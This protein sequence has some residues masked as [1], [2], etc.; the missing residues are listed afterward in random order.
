MAVRTGAQSIILG[1]LSALTW[2]W[3]CDQL[4][5]TL[6]CFLA[7][8]PKM[9]H[10]VW[11]LSHCDTVLKTITYG[12]LEGSQSDC[13]RPNVVQLPCMSGILQNFSDSWTSAN[14]D[15]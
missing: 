10:Q 11:C 4:Q 12:S 3:T 15:Q 8:G 14:A 5:A 13:P 2:S 1:F 9:N 6:D 7:C